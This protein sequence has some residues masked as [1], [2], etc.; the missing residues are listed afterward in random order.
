MVRVLCL[1]ILLLSTVTMLSQTSEN[2]QKMGAFKKLVRGFS[3]IDTNYIE[4]QHYNF[5][6]MMQTTYNYD[7]YRL[8]GASG[9]EVTLA[10]DVVMKM[11]PYVGWRWFFL[12]YTFD[13]RNISFSG[14]DDKRE[15][16]LSIYSSQIGVDLFYRRTGSDYKIRNAYMGDGVDV[17]RL[18]KVPFDGITVGITGFNL[19]YI[20]NHKRFSYP[21]AF[22]Q[23]TC[24]KISCGSW[25]AG[26]G[27]TNNSIDLD[28]EKLK[29]VVEENCRLDDVKIDSGLMFNKVKYFDI[30]ITGGYAYNWVFAKNWLFC[31]SASVALAYKH[32][33]GNVEEDNDHGFNFNNVN[34]DGIGRFGIVYNNTRWYAGASAIVRSYNYHK[35]RFATNNIFGSL[36]IYIGYNFGKMKGY[37]DKK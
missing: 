23:S 5:T 25:L 9:Q 17:S 33:R 28:Y 2:K 32:S 19:Y 20:F 15:L 31:G 14:T 24:Q 16:D 30:N 8:R 11:G 26:I 18:N 7:M 27:Y 22:A 3:E 34:V 29:T 6:F 1:Y 35:S 36:N 13:L 21:A 37:R 12:G 4:P 10:P